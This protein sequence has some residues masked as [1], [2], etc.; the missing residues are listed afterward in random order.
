MGES[1]YY[2]DGN[3][4]YYKKTGVD[5]LEAWVWFLTMKKKTRCN[6]TW[7]NKNLLCEENPI[8]FLKLVSTDIS[9]DKRQMEN[10]K[11]IFATCTINF[12][13]ESSLK[14]CMSCSWYEAGKFPPPHTHTHFLKSTK[15]RPKKGRKMG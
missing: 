14:K 6:E 1:F 2:K 11:K 13:K 15:R 12:F 9:Q 7:I 3:Y 4:K 8:H 5:T 10:W